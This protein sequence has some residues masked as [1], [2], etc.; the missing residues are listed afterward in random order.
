MRSP[1][2]TRN[3]LAR[4]GVDEQDL[5]LA[6]I[7]AVDEA[8][9]VEAGHAVAEGEAGAGE[10]EAGVA[11]GDGDGHAGG[12]AGPAAAGGQLDL[13]TGHQVGAGVALTGIGGHREVGV[14]TD[15]RDLQHG[16]ERTAPVQSRPCW[17]GWTSR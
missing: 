6:P 7:A 3:G 12:H 8:G 11:R 4:V 13:L 14:E 5:E 16:G 9:G 2:W 10:D 15:D 17:C 1:R